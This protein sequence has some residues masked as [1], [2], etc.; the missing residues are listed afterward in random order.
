MSQGSVYSPEVIIQRIPPKRLL[1]VIGLLVVILRVSRG[2]FLHQT[3]NMRSQLNTNE[4]LQLHLILG[5]VA[6]LLA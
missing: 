6:A 3:V 1:R 4:L 2:R 5:Y